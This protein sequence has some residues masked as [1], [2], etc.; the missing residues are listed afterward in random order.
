M[1]ITSVHANDSLKGH[2]T[3]FKLE[4]LKVAQSLP[5]KFSNNHV[6][7]LFPR[8]CDAAHGCKAYQH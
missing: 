5:Q 1:L 2:F 8:A 4:V 6:P 7:R 3:W